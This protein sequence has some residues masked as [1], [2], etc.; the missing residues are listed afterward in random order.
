MSLAP[1]APRVLIEA[2][3][4]LI[5]GAMID[6]LHAAGCVVIATDISDWNAG[7][8]LAD[9]YTRWPRVS[10]PDLWEQ[11]ADTLRRERVTHVIPSLDE[12]L[13]GWSERREAL[14]CEG[15]HVIVSPPETV[16]AC[17]D[18]WE[19]Y[20]A[21]QAM[22][23]PTPATSLVQ[24]HA[25]VK[26]RAGRGG[27]GVLRPAG[28]VPMEGMISQAEATG[29]ELSVDCLFDEAGAPIYIVPRRRQAVI[30]GKST[31]GE[32]VAAPAVEALVR[33]I[34]AGLTFRGLVNMQCFVDGERVQFIEINPRPA[35][36][37]ALAWAAT[38]NW[39]DLYLHR[40][41]AGQ[42]VTPRPVRHGLRMARYYAECFLD[43]GKPLGK[44]G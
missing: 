25:L 4:S 3:G 21:F 36:G 30:D 31:G 32:V 41:L 29:E 40:V 9:R 13:L 6:R 11:V 19:T 44:S 15:V 20:R 2:S 23:I 18:K 17:Q 8:A 16:A 24:D 27:K 34:A 38:E 26:P 7:A 33:R 28:P 37:M 42:P 5:A 10:A 14:A 12:M 35:G 22:G 43:P 39:F 1:S